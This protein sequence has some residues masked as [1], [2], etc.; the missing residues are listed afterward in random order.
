[1]DGVSISAPG[2]IIIH[3]EHAVV[4]GKEALACCINRRVKCFA[5]RLKNSENICLKIR[6]GE[7]LIDWTFEKSFVAQF[8]QESFSDASLP[9]SLGSHDLEGLQKSSE[10]IGRTKMLLLSIW[11]GLYLSISSDF[12]MKSDDGLS[13]EINSELVIGAGIGSS[14]SISVCMAAALLTICGHIKP[15]EAVTEGGGDYASRSFAEQDLKLI[16]GW[17]YEA[18]VIVHGKPSGVDNT[19]ITYGGALSY[20]NGKITFLKSF[21]SVD[22]LLVNSGVSRCTMDLVTGVRE[23]HSEFPE[24][25]DAIFDA[26]EK[27]TEAAKLNFLELEQASKNSED[28]TKFDNIYDRII[29]L[30]EMNQNLLRGIGVSHDSIENIINILKQHGLKGKLTGAGGGGCVFSVIKPGERNLS[31]VSPTSCQLSKCGYESW[32]VEI[33]CEGVRIESVTE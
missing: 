32:L 8:K 27:V 6:F 30:V 25:Y 9:S 13:L 12:F 3:G 11:I 18:E 29:A 26:I 1:M 33:G 5:K 16:N 2:K 19:I 7:K 28:S 15:I 17:A 4:Y 22:I 20:K 23:R 24:I 31:I 10:K 21:P 14:A